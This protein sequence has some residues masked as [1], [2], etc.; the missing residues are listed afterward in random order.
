[1]ETP[2]PGCPIATSDGE[3]L[4]IVREVRGDAIKVDAGGQPDYWLPM[5]E[6]LS[7]A[8][9]RVTMRFDKQHLADYRLDRPVTSS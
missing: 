8:P 1:M 7:S 3:A 2:Q 5:S 6:V 9:D 4:G